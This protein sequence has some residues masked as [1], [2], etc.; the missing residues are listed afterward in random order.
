MSKQAL[1]DLGVAIAEAGYN[2]TPR[3]RSAYEKGI[4]KDNWVSL[5]RSEAAAL[6]ADAHDIDG[7]R[8]WTPSQLFEEIDRRLRERNT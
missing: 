7:K 8:I 5:T 3:M 2:W 4:R 1:D 6:W